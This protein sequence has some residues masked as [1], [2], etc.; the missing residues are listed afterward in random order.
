MAEDSKNN[1]VHGEVGGSVTAGPLFVSEE[2]ERVAVAAVQA[3]L[4]EL[5]TQRLVD[6]NVDSSHVI[7]TVLSE[8]AKTAMASDGFVD[9]KVLADDWRQI[10]EL[11][12]RYG[13]D[14]HE[15]D[16]RRHFPV[17]TKYDRPAYTTNDLRASQA[18][19]QNRS[20]VDSSVPTSPKASIASHTAS[21]APESRT[22]EVGT[23]PSE[24]SIHKGGAEGE[25]SD[26]TAGGLEQVGSEPQAET[27]DVNESGAPNS[28]QV[29]REPQLPPSSASQTTASAD[30]QT[31][32]S[33]AGG[34]TPVSDPAPAGKETAPSAV[35][36]DGHMATAEKGVS[37]DSSLPDQTADTP[38]PGQGSGGG[39][40]S[41]PTGMLGRGIAGFAADQGVKWGARKG[42]KYAADKHLA[43]SNKT[44]AEV[45]AL[46]GQT[47]A[48]GGLVGSKTPKQIA[49]GKKMDETISAFEKRRDKHNKLQ[50]ALEGVSKNGMKGMDGVAD[51]AA[52][53]VAEKVMGKATAAATYGVN[54]NDVKDTVKDTTKALASGRLGEATK[55]LTAGGLV[56]VFRISYNWES[57][58]STVG[59]S[60]IVT[61]VL[62]SLLFFV[63]SAK[64]TM[65]ERLLVVA[66]WILLFFIVLLVLGLV[67]VQFCNGPAGW[68]VW[69]AS[70]FS[71]TAADINKFCE[72][73]GALQT[74]TKNIAR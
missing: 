47:G 56:I 63:S 62:G 10:Q 38:P 36:P 44:L 31:K 23:Q 12:E 29:A 8:M 25:S 19:N 18:E 15:P 21:S 46:G 30:N 14:L 9:P 41:G 65:L 71:K 26:V 40:S 42:Q 49:A 6:R 74:A 53:H 55:K 27:T 33:A 43:D 45:Q 64:L 51:L 35:A 24:E 73:I 4:Q 54:V 5:R 39:S 50:G 66:L 20:A 70:W 67:L 48:P 11:G 61:L 37:G 17:L 16:F 57:I 7:A 32:G 3:A 34:D 58:G 72:P 1:S 69:A 13:D 28:E 68:A 2:Q 22:S 59:L 52:A 60:L